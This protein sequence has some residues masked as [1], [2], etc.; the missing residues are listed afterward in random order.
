[1]RTQQARLLSG[2]P[3]GDA[4]RRLLAGYQLGVGPL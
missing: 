1:V 2:G 3:G 4:E